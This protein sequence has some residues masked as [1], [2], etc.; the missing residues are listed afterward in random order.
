MFNLLA[1][2]PFIDPINVHRI[3]YMLIV[4]LSLGIAITYKAIRVGDM[5]QYPKQVIAMTA[6]IVGI[7]ALL[8]LGSYLLI[9][10]IVPRILPAM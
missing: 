7:M 10:H 4:P 9:Q 3:W 6:Q 8:G 1:Y 2:T 5:K